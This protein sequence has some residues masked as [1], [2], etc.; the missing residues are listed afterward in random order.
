M[1]TDE[2]V[3]K[4]A[5]KAFQE[6][7]GM[8]EKALS[9]GGTKLADHHHGIL[10]FPWR[11]CRKLERAL[12]ETKGRIQEYREIE[13][14]LSRR[15]F[16]RAIARLNWIADQLEETSWQIARRVACT[17]LP[18]NNEKLLEQILSSPHVVSENLRKLAKELSSIQEKSIKE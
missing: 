5:I 1:H 6:N 18:E 4:R 10:C 9:E 17:T 2:D 16:N 14:E 12:K 13:E 3:T 8:A 7:R 11:W 15:E